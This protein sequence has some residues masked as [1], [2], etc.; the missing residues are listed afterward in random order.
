MIWITLLC[1][2]HKLMS[3]YDSLQKGLYHEN[4]PDAYRRYFFIRMYCP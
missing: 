4:Y 1:F 3:F 2:R